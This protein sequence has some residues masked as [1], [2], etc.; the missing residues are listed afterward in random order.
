MLA[1]R[2]YLLQLMNW[3]KDSKTQSDPPDRGGIEG[4]GPGIQRALRPLLQGQA[5]QARHVSFLIF[6]YIPLTELKHL[7]RF[8]SIV[9]GGKS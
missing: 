7:D 4:D 5:R 8:G 9:S 3:A 1:S 2:Y 6:M